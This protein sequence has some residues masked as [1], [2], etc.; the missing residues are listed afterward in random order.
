MITGYCI[1]LLPDMNMSVQQGRTIAIS[2]GKVMINRGADEEITLPKV[3]SERC[4]IRGNRGG[5]GKRR[6]KPIDMGIRQVTES[7]MMCEKGVWFS[8]FFQIIAG[9]KK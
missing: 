7:C 3:V 2:L 5:K 4:Y 6:G 9:H 8:F 1:V